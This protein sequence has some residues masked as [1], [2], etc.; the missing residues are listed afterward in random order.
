[1]NK[2]SSEQELAFR[3]PAKLTTWV[4]RFLYAQIIISILSILSNL[5]ELQL[6]FDFQSGDYSSA[7]IAAA[8]VS[9]QRQAA[10][11][12]LSSAIFVVSGFLILKWVYRANSNARRLGATH[13]RFTPGWAVGWYFIPL[14]NLVRPYQAMKE[15]WRAS[16]NPV[17]WK[18]EPVSSLLRWWWFFWIVFSFL[19]IASMESYFGAEGHDIDDLIALNMLASLSDAMGIPLALILIRIISK[20]YTMQRAQ[21][22]S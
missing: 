18:T 15:I 4:T 17:N 7:E 11:G 5:L 2:V 13:L 21:V 1:M 3:D 14:L 16:S 10:I 20:V 9:D 6:L 22:S 19:G 12:L 8:D